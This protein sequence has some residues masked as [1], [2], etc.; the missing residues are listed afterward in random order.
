MIDG[1]WRHARPI[2]LASTSGTRRRLLAACGLPVEPEAPGTDERALEA[3][4]GP[5]PPPEV[6]LK[7]AEAKAL[8][9]SA[10]NPDRFVIGADQILVCEGRVLSKA[11]SEEEAR[12]RL[13]E[14]QGRTHQLFVGVAIARS[15]MVEA[16]FC[17][18]ARLTMRTLD[19]AAIARY[20]DL[21]G[22]AVTRSVGAYEIEGLG[23]HLFSAIDGEHTTILGLPLVPLLANLRSLGV[24]EL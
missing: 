21:A 3:S 1:P 11:T 10:R 9:V 23:I 24:L 2:L 8:S 22:P 6:A 19:A 5:I 7:I 14:L 12:A 16:A 13:A 20:V 4:L 18:E 15:G 17:E